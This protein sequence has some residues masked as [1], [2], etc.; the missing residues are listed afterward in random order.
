MNSLIN[1]SKSNFT[2]KTPIATVKAGF[3]S[4][5]SDYEEAPLSLDELLVK[6][7][8]ATFLLKVSGD[9]MKDAGIWNG[10][11]L[12]VDSSLAAKNGDVVV[13]I[14]ENEFTVKQFRKDKTG[15]YLMPANDAYPT[16]SIQ[17]S[18][19]SIWGVVTSVIRK[20]R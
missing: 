5:A 4:P 19:T 8:T 7:E 3:P 1:L 15:L 14:V 10:D 6:N 18:E 12:I 13:A 17:N 16:I 20:L 2:L 9:S 11:I